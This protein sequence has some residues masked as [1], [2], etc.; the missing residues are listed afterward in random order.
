MHFR[1]PKT[2]RLLVSNIKNT[3]YAE[4][5]SIKPTHCGYKTKK[6][7]RLCYMWVTDCPSGLISP[8]WPFPGQENIMFRSYL[9]FVRHIEFSWPEWL[10]MSCIA[11]KGSVYCCGTQCPPWNSPGLQS[12][13]LRNWETFLE[14]VFWEGY[15][16]LR[17]LWHNLLSLSIR[18]YPLEIWLYS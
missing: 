8:F 3:T 1:S 7:I 4:R 9:Y 14:N 10:L 17:I 16:V 12:T 13:C 2:K 18:L 15:L 6:A 5:L 11:T